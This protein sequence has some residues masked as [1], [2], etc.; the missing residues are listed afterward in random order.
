MTES[1]GSDG[2][3]FDGPG[4]DHGVFVP[5]SLMFGE[6]LDIPLVQVTI[7]GTLDPAKEWA[8]GKA[9]ASLRYEHNPP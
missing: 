6:K 5:F 4:L 1:R 8:L 3:G 7:D 2:R 9:V